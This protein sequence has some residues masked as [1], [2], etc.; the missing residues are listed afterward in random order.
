M[1]PRHDVAMAAMAAREMRLKYGDKSVEYAQA[2]DRM[3]RARHG[4]KPE[5][6]CDEDMLDVA[7]AMGL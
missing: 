7:M 3:E 2:L 1:G 4:N 5:P 6:K